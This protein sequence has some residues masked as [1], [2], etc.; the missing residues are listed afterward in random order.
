MPETFASASSTMCAAFQAT[1]KRRPNQ[2]A[3]RTAGDAVSITFAQWDA[4]VRTLAA[5]FAAL[6][7]N[8]GDKVA[9]MMVNRPEFFVIDVA[10]QH[11]GATPFSIYNT[12]A[13]EQMNYYFGD[14]GNTV[15]IAEAQ[16]VE[17]I[18]KG[19]EGTAVEHVVCI[20]GNPEGTVT[21]DSVAASGAADFDF[22]AAWR[23]VEPD[24]VL[25]LI[26][27]SGT[28][29]SPKGVQLT[30]K[31]MLA[32]VNGTE[33][34]MQATP[35]DRLISFLPAAHIADR[36]AGLYT[37]EV[38]GTQVTTVADRKDF[39]ATVVEVRPTIFGA[40]PQVWQK[41]KAG[42]DVKLAEATG[43]KAKLAGW[44]VAVGRE[45]SDA[46]LDGKPVGFALNVQAG[47]ADKL[48]LSKLRAALGLDVAKLALSGA[49]PIS[50]DVVR[51]FNGVG[52]PVS[53]AW[54]MSELSGLV[55]ISPP[56]KIRV[57][58]VGAPVPG[59][60]IKIAEDDG[61][62]LVRGPILMKGYLNKPEQTA[63]AID[64]DGWL[65]TGDVGE[66]DS[67]GFLKI[68]D[69][70]KELIINA[71]GKNMSP[72]NIENWV[73]AFSPLIGQAVAIGDNR[74]YNVALIALDPDNAK[75]FAEKLGVSE[76]AAVLA[77]HPELLAIVDNAVEQA[78]AKLSQVEQIKK[79]KIVPD[80][81]EP[82]SDVLT[83]T[84][85]LRRK[86]INERY[87]EQIEA[88]YA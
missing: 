10:L 61:E 37:Q 16:F 86:P 56:G 51:F 3:V 63:E 30:H 20:D 68:V 84:M 42:I 78:N 55:T 14:S 34:L 46:K 65:H 52:I 32:M 49:A 50:A 77:A 25:T 75:V 69:R 67:E 35:D 21:L 54:G 43:V 4:Q 44:A 41:V 60:E 57:G 39:L 45:A 26:Y 23:A 87:S 88:L 27:T 29:G 70:K 22:D 36:W 33:L 28:T 48:V 74:K 53:D 19:K 71:G 80:F 7:V 79:Y 17:K 8:R 31:N 24:D 11:L 40:V 38:V 59:V 58:T 73:K 13:P 47:L 6:G 72:S 66:L 1:V 9:L 82:G 18:L 12:S 2:I 83:P 5:G 76:D 15:V 64:S 81:W 85:K 62:V